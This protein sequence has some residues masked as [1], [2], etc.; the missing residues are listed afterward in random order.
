MSTISLFEALVKTTYQI[1]ITKSTDKNLSKP[2]A[3]GAGFIIDYRE[4]TFFVTA[5]HNIHIEDYELNER[6]G[7]DNVVSI[8]NNISN[9]EEFS[10][11]LTP[12]GG[13]HYMEK[14][15]IDKL[16]K[17]YEMI[18]VTVAMMTKEKHFNYPFLTDDCTLN[19]EHIIKAGEQKFHFVEELLVEPNFESNYSVY[20]KIKPEIKGLF[21]H[22][23]DTLKEGIKFVNEVGDYYLFNTQDP[24]ESEEDWAGLSGSPMLD[25]NGQCVGVVCSVNPGTNSVFVK[26]IS[27]VKILME[28]AIKQEELEQLLKN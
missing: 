5:D 16:E 10:T 19:G 9:K 25:D 14:F 18:D 15:N 4:K 26:P 28:I 21:L 7:I 13:F 1:Q 6:T 12:I 27:K 24:I 17:G 23:T 3:F 11:M 20:G 8:F 2:I 22:R